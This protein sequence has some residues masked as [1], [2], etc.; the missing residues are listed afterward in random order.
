MP[1]VSEILNLIAKYLEKP[2]AEMREKIHWELSRLTHNRETHR[3]IMLSAA[4]LV[5]LVPLI[6]ATAN[7]DDK[8]FLMGMIAKLEKKILDSIFRGSAKKM[9]GEDAAQCLD[10]M[11]NSGGKLMQSLPLVTGPKR[12]STSLRAS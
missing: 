3:S 5:A 6:D 9:V 1:S 11:W 8:E 10:P 2:V 7:E 4:A 12:K